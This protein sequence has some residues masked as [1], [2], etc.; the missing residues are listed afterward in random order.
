MVGLFTDHFPCK[1]GGFVFSVS[2]FMV[3][4][5]L[6]YYTIN[7]WSTFFIYVLY[8]FSLVF[9]FVLCVGILFFKDVT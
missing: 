3:N 8:F 4:E 1:S 9:F 5:Y 6:M 7:I 2:C